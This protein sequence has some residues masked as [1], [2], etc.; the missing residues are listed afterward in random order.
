MTLPK[1]PII[2]V[3][4]LTAGYEEYVILENVSFDIYPG[5]IFIILGGSGCGKTTLLK[6]MIG[7]LKPISGQ[8][9]ITA[10]SPVGTTERR[11]RRVTFLR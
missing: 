2:H 9:R 7:L 8:I 6:Q 4:K 11:R 3:D 1:E 10:R 5:E